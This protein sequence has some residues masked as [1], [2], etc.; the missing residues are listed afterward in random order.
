[1][2]AIARL[3]AAQD[4]NVNAPGGFKTSW[5][6]L[7]GPILNEANDRTMAIFASLLPEG[8]GAKLLNTLNISPRPKNPPPK[9]VLDE[10]AKIGGKAGL[11]KA[12]NSLFGGSP[13]PTAYYRVELELPRK[14]GWTCELLPRAIKEGELHLAEFG[15]SVNIEEIGF[16]VEG[17]VS[18]IQEVRITYYHT[19][20]IFRVDVTAN[21]ILKINDDLTL[22]IADDIADFAG[23]RLFKPLT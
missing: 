12:I 21:S 3:P 11:A 4:G 20:E 5:R 18:G 23:T 16:R 22:P 10:S 17:G 2:T 15:K 8:D 14:D 19:P 1:M 7:V 6:R 9:D 13:T